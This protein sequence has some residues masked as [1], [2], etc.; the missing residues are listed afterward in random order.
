MKFQYWIFVVVFWL[1]GCARLGDMGGDGGVK[2]PFMSGEDWW[3]SQGANDH[4]GNLQGAW[5]FNYGSGWDDYERPVLAACTGK[6]H[7]AKNDGDWGNTVVIDCDHGGY[8]RTAHHQQLFV[9]VGQPVVQGQVIGTC[10]NTGYSSGPHIHAQWQNA[11][12][13]DADSY[14]LNDV[15][16]PQTGDNVVSGNQYI[17]DRARSAGYYDFNP[18]SY[19]GDSQLP[20]TAFGAPNQWGIHLYHDWNS[21]SLYTRYN[22][23]KNCYVLNYEGGAYD[24]AI[25]YDAL[26]GAR[27]AYIVGWDQWLGWHELPP[28]GD[29]TW[30]PGEGGPNSWL[31]MPITN[32]YYSTNNQWCQNF[33]RGYMCQ[34]GA[35]A[36]P[37]GSVA[38]GQRWDGIWDSQWSYAFAEA[39]ERNGAYPMVGKTD[40]ANPA[41]HGWEDVWVQNYVAGQHGDCA[42]IYSFDTH[43]AFLVRSGF[44]E[45]YQEQG[46][47]S[48]FGYPLGDEQDTTLEHLPYDPYC[49]GR[50]YSSAA[51]CVHEFCGADYSSMQ[52][53]SKGTMCYNKGGGV[54]FGDDYYGFIPD[55]CDEYE[56]PENGIDDNCDGVIDDNDYDQ[57]GSWWSDGDCDDTNAN[58][59][60]GAAEETDGVDND[61]DGEVDETDNIPVGCAA[62]ASVE[63]ILEPASNWVI[64]LYHAGG[65][66]YSEPGEYLCVSQ[67]LTPGVVLDFNAYSETQG[68]LSLSASQTARETGFGV[69]NVEGTDRLDS[70]VVVTDNY[71]TNVECYP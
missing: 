49:Q 71:G 25:V 5:D 62:G 68:W 57:D 6:V 3:I 61:C 47:P 31:G 32:S 21:N 50:G 12:D 37:A 15:G 29:S 58:V 13:H 54:G 55:E 28:D 1:S 24:G 51:Q 11:P 22:N 18:W 16:N 10:G 41:V 40:P 60:P 23:A 14:S 56:L 33:Q 53:F 34:T 70:A 30:N 42:L 59:Y 65:V 45:Y 44:W 7:T 20:D 48:T 2:A 17:F 35:Y 27:R 63:V 43:E 64:Q 52:R 8:F 19:H 67:E 69:L 38:P 36:Y 4:G 26:G 39:F 46:G 9:Q 66:Y